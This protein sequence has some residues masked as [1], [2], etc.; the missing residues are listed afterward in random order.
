MIQDEMN[1]WDKYIRQYRDDPEDFE[2]ICDDMTERMKFSTIKFFGVNQYHKNN[3]NW[4]RERMSSAQMGGW[5][6]KI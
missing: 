2:F 4:I 1:D 6:A 3:K 5:L